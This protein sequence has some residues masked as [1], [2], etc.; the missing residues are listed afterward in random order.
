MAGFVSGLLV[1]YSLEE[2][3]DYYTYDI[4]DKHLRLRVSYGFC[5]G[6]MFPTINEG[7]KITSYTNVEKNEIKVYDIVG[8][9]NER[10]QLNGYKKGFVMHAD[11]LDIK[12]FN[13]KGLNMTYQE[14]K[15]KKCVSTTSRWNISSRKL[16]EKGQIEIQL[17]VQQ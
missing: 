11:H 14:N 3:D 9:R 7:Y 17:R 15:L 10:T 1:F 12:R 4:P 6:S 16:N 13:M 2:L 5:C 8:F